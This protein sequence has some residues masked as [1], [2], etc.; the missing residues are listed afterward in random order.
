MF[1]CEFWVN[2]CSSKAVLIYIYICMYVCMYVCN[3]N[4]AKLLGGSHGLMDRVRLITR[5]LRVRVSV[6]A[7]IVGGGSEYPA[8]SPPSKPRLR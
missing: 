7:G 6:L 5:R 2:K 4:N 3:N 8:L 1:P